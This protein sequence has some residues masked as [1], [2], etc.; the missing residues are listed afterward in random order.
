MPSR[1]KLVGTGANIEVAVKVCVS[2][3]EDTK[4]VVDRVVLMAVVVVVVETSIVETA[5]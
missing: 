2:V 1:A 3:M 4:V 5:V